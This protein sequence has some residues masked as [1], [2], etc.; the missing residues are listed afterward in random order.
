MARRAALHSLITWHASRRANT[1]KS[2]MKAGFFRGGIRDS[3]R[4]SSP[5]SR[6]RIVQACASPG[7]SR[8]FL[9]FLFL[10]KRFFCIL[11]APATY[12]EQIHA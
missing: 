3:F 5:L 9:L 4:D 11:I 10:V 7:T 2:R 6:S 1:A 8:R 12:M